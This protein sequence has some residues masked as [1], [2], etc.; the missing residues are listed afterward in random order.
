M[1]TAGGRTGARAECAR[2]CGPSLRQNLIYCI[3]IDL[4]AP[5]DPNSLSQFHTQPNNYTKSSWMWRGVIWR[6]SEDSIAW[7]LKYLEDKGENFLS[8]ILWRIDR[9][10][11]NNSRCY[12]APAAY[13]CAVTSRNNRRGDAQDVFCRSAPRL[14]DSADRVLLSE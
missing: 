1:H 7:I 3:N 11:V 2:N 10:S 6:Y 4:L 8:I 12:G 9:G 14:Y 13:A 5:R